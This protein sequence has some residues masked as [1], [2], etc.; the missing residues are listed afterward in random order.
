MGIEL[1]NVKKGIVGHVATYELTGST[2]G[3]KGISVHTDVVFEMSST[4]VKASMNL[5]FMPEQEDFNAAKERLALYLEIFAKSLRE[6]GEPT[7]SIPVL[8]SRS[9]P[10]IGMESADENE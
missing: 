5:D 9:L 3:R 7:L 1:K 2:P 4:G 10:Q 6:V 8:V